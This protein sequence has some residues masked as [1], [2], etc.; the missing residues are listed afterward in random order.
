MGS[1]PYTSD[2]KYSSLY[3][4]GRVLPVIGF[5]FYQRS[6]EFAE[7]QRQYPGEVGFNNSH[8]ANR[9]RQ[10]SIF[11]SYNRAWKIKYGAL[12]EEG[13]SLV[14]IIRGKI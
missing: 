12:L 9:N 6:D 11:T 5:V 8:N 14:Q 4:P 7:I 10:G 13:N 1:S 2:L 3:S